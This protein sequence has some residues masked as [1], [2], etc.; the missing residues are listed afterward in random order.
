[1]E[2][3]NWFKNVGTTVAAFTVTNFLV[4]CGSSS[5]D[6]VSQETATTGSGCTEGT[7]TASAN[8]NVSLT[9]LK[10]IAD[11][12]KAN[13]KDY[14]NSNQGGGTT[15]ATKVYA[16]KHVLSSKE[17]ASVEASG[18][19]TQTLAQ[20]RGMYM[21]PADTGHNATVSV[22]KAADGDGVTVTWSCNHGC[23]PV[24][25]TS[26][27]IT[28]FDFWM[29]GDT[30]GPKATHEITETVAKN[31]EFTKDFKAADL[32]TAKF[33]Y[34]IVHCN[35]H[36]GRICISPLELSTDSTTAEAA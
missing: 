33:A 15:Y 3:R 34:L 1:M 35:N 26:H 13:N 28:A 31:T 5:D 21:D 6:A 19:T 18:E 32:G 16:N 22:A 30:S 20:I 27:G 9:D 12:Y 4:N 7:A 25:A 14:I 2:R 36:G 17:A 24:S 23:E 11:Y 10:A 8:Q 29:A